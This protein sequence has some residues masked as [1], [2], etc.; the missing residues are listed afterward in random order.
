MS[1]TAKKTNKKTNKKTFKDYY[2]DPAYR[3]AHLEKMKKRVV[4]ECGFETSQC[5]LARHKKSRNHKKRMDEGTAYIDEKLEEKFSEA[6]ERQDE[7]E[8]D[9]RQLNRE[10]RLLK[11]AFRKLT[12]NEK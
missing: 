11:K 3:E 10:I 2:A 8:E 12:A 1:K 4:C 9:I 5:N 7:F 6:S